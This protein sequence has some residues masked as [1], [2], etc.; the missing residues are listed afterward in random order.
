[1]SNK[2]EIERVLDELTPDR[3]REWTNAM[4]GFKPLSLE[5]MK[6]LAEKKG[7]LYT[8]FKDIRFL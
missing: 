5:K 2:I 6:I 4:K 8:S 3:V 7:H 1:M